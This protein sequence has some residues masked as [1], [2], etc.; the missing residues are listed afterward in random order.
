MHDQQLRRDTGAGNS[1]AVSASVNVSR[2]LDD[3]RI[4]LDG[5]EQEQA[6]AA[7]GQAGLAEGRASTECRDR[8]RA[9]GGPRAGAR[10]RKTDTTAPR[11]APTR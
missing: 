7:E 8:P 10:T 9:A 5:G 11:I 1:N 2:L 3:G 6:G 4:Q